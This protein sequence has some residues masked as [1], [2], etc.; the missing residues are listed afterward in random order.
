[1]LNQKRKYCLFV[2]EDLAQ[3][4][5]DF[6]S[7]NELYGMKSDLY[8]YSDLRKCF[9]R[10]GIDLNT[11]YI[12]SPQE[13]EVVLCVN[14]TD[15]FATYKRTSQNKL[16]VLILTE[17]PVYNLKDWN[18]KR[19]QLF[20]KVFTYNSDLVSKNPIKYKFLAYPID[21]N[22]PKNNNYI[23][24]QEFLTKKNSCMVASAFAITKG[25]KQ[26]KS[27]LYERYKILV[28]YNKYAPNQLDYFSRTNPKEKFVYYRGASLLNKVSKKIGLK[29]ADYLYSKK[30]AKLYRGSVPSLNKTDTLANYKFNFCLENSLGVKGYITEKIFDA[31]FSQTVPIYLGAED[32][33][34]YI[35]K[36]CYINYSDFKNIADLHHFLINMNYKRYT[37]YQVN[38]T[39]FLNSTAIDFFTVKKFISTLELEITQ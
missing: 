6:F 21:F 27:L 10:V 31:F 16:V 12:N 3:K 36:D 37:E 20:D 7:S 23:S 33:H 24:E 18:T 1:M 32:A 5:D 34:H 13:S 38:I 2:R 29:I 25:N 35:P 26:H 8:M 14:E 30:I 19:H 22:V 4:K 9:A 39:H 17:P 28:W 11:Q 15:Y